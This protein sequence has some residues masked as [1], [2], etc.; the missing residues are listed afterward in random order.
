MNANR[1]LTSGSA[2]KWTSCADHLLAADRR[3]GEPC[4]RGRSGSADRRTAAGPSS[5]LGIGEQQGASLVRSEAPGEPDGQHAGIEDLVRP[6]G[7]GVGRGPADH[8]GDGA[9][10]ERSR[11][12]A[13]ARAPGAPQLRGRACPDTFSQRAP[14]V[15]AQSGGNRRSSTSAISGPS[16]VEVC[17]PFVIEP[18]GTSS[19]GTSGHS[20]AK[21]TRETSPWS[22]L[23]AFE[24]AARRSPM[25]AM[26]K[27]GLPEGGG[28]SASDPRTRADSLANS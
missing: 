23:T 28:R 5:R 26:L 21:I 15:S 10:H 24:R 7:F 1:P 18:I 25:T 12:V 13:R 6:G 4:R 11:R 22:L 9:G 20:S 2:A 3:E 27:V 14:P 16:H 19:A 17:T 8:S